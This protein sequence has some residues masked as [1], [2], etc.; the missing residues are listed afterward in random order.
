MEFAEVFSL[1]FSS[2][3][4]KSLRKRRKISA[5]WFRNRFGWERERERERDCFFSRWRWWWMMMIKLIAKQKLIEFCFG[6]VKKPYLFS[7]ILSISISISFR[8]WQLMNRFLYK[9]LYRSNWDR[10]SS[11]KIFLSLSIS[12]SLSP[13]FLRFR[14]LFQRFSF[15]KKGTYCV[16]RAKLKQNDSASKKSNESN[17]ISFW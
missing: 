2:S 8:Y 10:S 13:S 16:S 11:T 15:I 3:S 17:L 1:V 12:L 4:S 7:R 5:L 6:F 14:S 9:P